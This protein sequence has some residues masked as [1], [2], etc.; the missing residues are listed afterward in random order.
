[1]PPLP[2]IPDDIPDAEVLERRHA[3]YQ[4]ILTFVFGALLV[5]DG[6]WFVH[7]FFGSGRSLGA[8]IRWGWPLF[9]LGHWLWISLGH[10]FTDGVRLEDATAEHVG[11]YRRE[12]V[13]AMVRDL[14]RP[15]RGR[16]QPGLY[17]SRSSEPG[18]EC[19]DKWLLNFLRPL[20]AIHITSM[21][22][23]VMRPDE[24]RAILAHELGHFYRYTHALRRGD[25]FVFLF[26]GLAVAEAGWLMGAE[27]LSNSVLWGVPLY[28]TLMV[29]FGFSMLHLAREQEYLADLFG[30]RHTSKLSMVNAL[31]QLGKGL[32]VSER[33]FEKVLR[34]VA[35][36]PRLAAD[37]LPAIVKIVDGALPQRLLDAG[38]EE[39]FLD[40][41]FAS[42]EM[43]GVRQE[44]G[45]EARKASQKKLDELQGRYKNK[46][47][48]QILDW[49]RFDFDVRDLRVDEKEYPHLVRRLVE[50][51]DKQLVDFTFDNVKDAK[52]D[53]HPTLRQRILFLEKNFARS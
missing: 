37:S 35:A 48:Y 12:D 51:P 23:H 52:D 8:G 5:L 15:F 29:C 18:A 14:L 1:M 38:E 46:P 21:L 16:E 28:G 33:I 42:E 20:N 22:F 25:F 32:E 26:M 19:V 49:S 4:R 40:Q 43:D 24:L 13:Q 10:L 3:R 11:R 31:L 27:G 45:E 47:G 9:G 30:A 53:E 39:P 50:E 44:L 41:A 6:V 2:V 34:R 17:V 7:L 36:D